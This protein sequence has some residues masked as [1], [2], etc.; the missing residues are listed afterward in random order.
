M[1]KLK[2]ILGKILLIAAGIYAGLFVVF[3]FDLDGKLLFRFV[4]P[5]LVRHYDGMKRR[6]PLSVG[7]DTG[8]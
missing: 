4:E 1:R 2:K 6:D 7:Y 8:K 5:L 3:Y